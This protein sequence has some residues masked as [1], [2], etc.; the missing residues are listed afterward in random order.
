[1]AIPTGIALKTDFNRHI[2]H[3]RRSVEEKTICDRDQLSPMFLPQIG[4]IGDGQATERETLLDNEM[5]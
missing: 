2:E 4:R 3:N 1:L 5:H